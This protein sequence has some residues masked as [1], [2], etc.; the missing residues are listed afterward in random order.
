MQA[1]QRLLRRFFLFLT[2]KEKTVNGKGNL[3]EIHKRFKLQMKM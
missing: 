3:D 2:R 1:K